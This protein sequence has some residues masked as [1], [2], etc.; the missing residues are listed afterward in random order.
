[1][2]PN[3]FICKSVTFRIYLNPECM[4]G[5]DSAPASDST[6]KPPPSTS[7]VSASTRAFNVVL[8]LAILATAVGLNYYMAKS[9]A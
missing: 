2:R 7:K 1:M 8:P 9:Q 3:P 4:Q 6:A 5:G